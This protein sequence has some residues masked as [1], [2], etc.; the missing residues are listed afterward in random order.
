M[1]PILQIAL[2]LY[3]CFCSHVLQVILPPSTTS[4]FQGWRYAFTSSFPYFLAVS[5][6]P[7][8]FPSIIL[9][10]LSVRVHFICLS[11]T[12]LR[13]GVSIGLKFRL[14]PH[15]ISEDDVCP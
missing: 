3:T 11:F 7:E 5:I 8:F 15:R 10:A 14:S 9:S 2:T 12:V 1:N 13:G 6:F 4:I